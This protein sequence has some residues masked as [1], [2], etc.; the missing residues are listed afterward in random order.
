[1]MFYRLLP[2]KAGDKADFI[3]G[4][5]TCR[6]LLRMGCFGPEAD[7]ASSLRSFQRTLSKPLYSLH[8]LE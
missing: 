2:D 8:S 6:R 7:L 5:L 3:R 1:M 4:K